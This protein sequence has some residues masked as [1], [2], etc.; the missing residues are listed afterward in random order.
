[1]ASCGVWL[2][3]PHLLLQFYAPLA[4]VWAGCTHA[5]AGAPDVLPML[6][7]V[8]ATEGL[9]KFVYLAHQDRMQHADRVV[10]CVRRA[11]R[12]QPAAQASLLRVLE[13]LG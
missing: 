2:R 13:G 9:Q 5:T 3:S 7:F 1:M 8:G 4:V 11:Q 6:L 12:V 10:V